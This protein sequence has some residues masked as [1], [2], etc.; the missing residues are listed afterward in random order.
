MFSNIRARRD[1]CGK[2]LNE[3]KGKKPVLEA[4]IRIIENKMQIELPILTA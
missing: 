3:W 1:L 4:T 2:G